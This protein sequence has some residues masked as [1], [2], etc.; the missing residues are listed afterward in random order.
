MTPTAPLNNWYRL[1]FHFPHPGDSNLQGQGF[2]QFLDYRNR[3]ISVLWY[4]HIYNPV[5]LIRLISNYDIWFRVVYFL[6]QLL[7]C[8]HTICLQMSDDVVI[9]AQASNGYMMLRYHVVEC[10]SDFASSG[11]PDMT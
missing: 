1:C 7:V 5:S 8:V 9:L 2:R 6:Q 4:C 10:I 11:H 3:C